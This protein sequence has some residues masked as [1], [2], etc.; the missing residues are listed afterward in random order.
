VLNQTN[1]HVPL[2][3]LLI[4]IVGG[5]TIGPVLMLIIG[6][7]SE[8]IGAIG[9][10]TLD[11]YISAYGNP[12]L[13]TT[14]T[15]TVIF[16]LGTSVFSTVLG[17]FLAYLSVR[18]DIPLKGLFSFLPIV[19]M[20]I[21]HV[22]FSSA[23]IALLNPTNGMFNVMLRNL[24]GLARGPFNIYSLGGMIFLEGMLD[25]PVTYLVM[26]PAM[27]SFDTK[28]EEAARV[29]G[30]SNFHTL[31]TVT[32]P[33]LKPAILATFT[34]AIIRSLASFAVPRMVGVPGRIYVLTTHI[35][36]I[37]SIGWSPDYGQ[38]A[39]IGLI[40][41][42][43]AIVL[44]YLYRRL[45]SESAQFVTV[46]GKGFR[47]TE[48][49]LG[50]AKYPLFIVCLLFF[51]F[52]VVIPLA[53]LIYMSFLPYTMVPSTRAFSMM[54]LDNWKTVINSARMLS[55]LKNSA[56]LAIVGAT[57]AILLSIF[58]AYIIVKV[59]S[60]ASTFLES[61][62]FLSFSFPGMII[63]VGFMWFLVKTPL[64]ATLGGLLVAYVGT[65][66]PYGV[67]PLRSAFTQIDEELEESA[68]VFGASFLRSLR[69]IVVPL[70]A[71]AVISAWVLTAA[72]FIRE[73]S[74]SVVLSRPGTEVLTVEI[75]KLADD[76]LWGQVAAL[77][78]I[79]VAL[80]TILVAGANLLK[81]P[82]AQSRVKKIKTESTSGSSAIP[83]P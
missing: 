3:A 71:P 74:V 34:L 69:D 54:S 50:R 68:R 62:T 65:Y 32:L 40:V 66:L 11:K 1:R 26:A 10:F 45:I 55:A 7:F 41:L 56:F 9:K 67:R 51:A 75:M 63:G 8:G 27:V 21:P 79:M 60:K 12:N 24:F 30:A 81:L 73:L 64:Y 28:L 6:S 39:A 59:K 78:L 42:A 49:K 47:P 17:A 2:T 83:V 20:M 61:L 5:L 80:S 19:P 36:R 53:T 35:H 33:V 4:L 18:T 58:V 15:N 77:G 38:A 48:I 82:L 37:I 43:V 16:V 72:M 14:L 29:S 44:V 23:W 76:G 25:L 22:L 70:L 31:R 46:T 57:V 52:L 13:P